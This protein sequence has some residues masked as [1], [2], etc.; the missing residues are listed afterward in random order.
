MLHQSQTNIPSYLVL[1]RREIC[2]GLKIDPDEMPFVGE[3]VQVS[4]AELDWQPALEKLSSPL[5]I[6]FTHT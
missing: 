5:C 4:S 3:L 1:L 2:A 6:T